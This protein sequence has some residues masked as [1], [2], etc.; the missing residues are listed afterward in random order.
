MCVV[1]H[2]SHIFLN[3]IAAPTTSLRLLSA[4]APQ[5]QAVEWG[6]MTRL[7]YQA[8]R[9]PAGHILSIKSSTHCQLSAFICTIVH[10]FNCLLA[11]GLFA[12]AF[13]GFV[14]QAFRRSV[15]HYFTYFICILYDFGDHCRTYCC[16]IFA[17]VS[18]RCCCNCCI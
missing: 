2:S 14:S 3:R 1:Q 16:F 4:R 13:R 10:A 7:H 15:A 12:Q 9:Q 8:A 18:T 6:S 5:L 11:A 17:S